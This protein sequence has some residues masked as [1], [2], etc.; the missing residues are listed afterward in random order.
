MTLP[1]VGWVSG[2]QVDPDVDISSDQR[3]AL[4]FIDAVV[5]GQDAEKRSQ[6]QPPVVQWDSVPTQIHFFYH[7][8][9]DGYVELSK[10]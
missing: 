4:H 8:L 5:F 10:I 1:A 7:A 3:D 6:F 2:R 9:T